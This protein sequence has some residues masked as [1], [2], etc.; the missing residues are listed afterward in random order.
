MLTLLVGM[1]RVMCGMVGVDEG[2]FRNE[3]KGGW[4]EI[5]FVLVGSVVGLEL[6]GG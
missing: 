2:G 3:V 1:C 6:L 5:S 4:L